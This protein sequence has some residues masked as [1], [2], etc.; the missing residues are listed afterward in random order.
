[1]SEQNKNSKRFL[2]IYCI[3]IFVF[4]VS[5]ILIASFS[6]QRIERDAA[7]L[8]TK[9]EVAENLAADKG[10]LLDGA[11]TENTLLK[12]QINALQSEKTALSSEKESL[13]SQKTELEKKLL[14]SQKLTEIVNLV[15]L[16]N[17]G[18]A[19]NAIKSFEEAGLH[20]VLSPAEI[21]IYYSVK[22]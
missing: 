2:I 1:M 19:N 21:E 7:A 17:K 12:E 15:R 22:K 9:A 6:Q 5:L 16:R 11:M 14:A 3:A 13:L 4:A 20:L 8:I 18:A 10:T